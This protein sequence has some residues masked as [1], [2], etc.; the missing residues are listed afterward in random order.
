[1][2]KSSRRK[3]AEDSGELALTVGGGAVREGLVRSVSRALSKRG[4]DGLG[5]PVVVLVRGRKDENAVV[6]VCPTKANALEGAAWP[7]CEAARVGLLAKTFAHLERPALPHIA[8]VSVD[9]A[10]RIFK[11]RGAAS[12]PL[13]LFHFTLFKMLLAASPRT[14]GRRQIFRA[15]PELSHSEQRD[16]V[17]NARVHRLREKLSPELA[18][19]LIH[20]AGD[21]YRLDLLPPRRLRRRS[22]RQTAREL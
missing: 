11:Y 21:G 19:K 22:S 4:C 15:F 18:D 6:V 12:E 8:N 14:L 2:S 9:Y 7:N 20:I 13:C 5:K 1:M 16:L 3:R 10:R 17:L